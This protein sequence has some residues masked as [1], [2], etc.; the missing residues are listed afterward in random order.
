MDVTTICFLQSY[1]QLKLYALLNRGV[2]LYTIIIIS[3]NL[4]SIFPFIQWPEIIL[5]GKFH[6]NE[7]IILGCFIPN[8]NK[9]KAKEFSTRFNHDDPERNKEHV[10][11]NANTTTAIPQDT[12]EKKYK[13]PTPNCATTSKYKQN[14]INHLKLCHTSN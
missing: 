7:Y 2:S 6:R 14:I 8:S 11:G 9:N 10:P 1:P 3:E 4:I 12:S 13:C 5:K